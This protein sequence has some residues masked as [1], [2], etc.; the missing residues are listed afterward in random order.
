MDAQFL[1]HDH[2]A[3]L[4]VEQSPSVQPPVEN[5]AAPSTRED[6]VLIQTSKLETSPAPTLVPEPDAD[7]ESSSTTSLLSPSEKPPVYGSTSLYD[8]DPDSATDVIVNSSTLGTA[9][10]ADV[11]VK[12]NGNGRAINGDGG[13]KVGTKKEK[14]VTRSRPHSPDELILPALP[15][16]P[17][18][19]ASG[20]F[21][22]E[23]AKNVDVA[24]EDQPVRPSTGGVEEQKTEVSPLFAVKIHDAVEHDRNSA[25]S[26]TPTPV[27]SEATA[28]GEDAAESILPV[29]D[30]DASSSLKSAPTSLSAGP[31][32]VTY[33]DGTG[34]GS[35][36]LKSPSSPATMVG[37]P[38]IPA[39][40]TQ[41][42]APSPSP[43][44]ATKS[45]PLPQASASQPTG[46]SR[47]GGSVSGSGFGLP[48]LVVLGAAAVLVV[49][50]VIAK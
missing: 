12:G 9:D 25:S 47:R 37:T 23:A 14:V 4:I 40:K 46:L 29:T 30:S 44:P 42:L 3:K 5:S 24:V 26:G 39:S 49:A 31:L 17:P 38:E 2:L 1:A 13:D 10:G 21:V 7:V 19:P 8:G 36:S 41:T 22:M 33:T 27:E 35:P 16:L 43:S 15:P 20:G 32:A 28:N 11:K 48:W 34:N 50:W 6:A 18:T 45:T